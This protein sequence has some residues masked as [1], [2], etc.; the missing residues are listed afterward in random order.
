MHTSTKNTKFYI[1]ESAKTNFM[2]ISKNWATPLTIASFTIMSITG[3]LL[4][5][6]FN[7]GIGKLVHKWGGL[8]LTLAVTLHIIAN[9]FG[10]KRYFSNN[11][12][13]LIFF[14]CTLAFLGVTLFAI[15]PAKQQKIDKIILERFI[16]TPIKII[17]PLTKHST[18]EVINIL[19]RE[20]F[21]NFTIDQSLN[22]ITRGDN[23]QIKRII[24]IILD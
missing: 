2:K 6:H 17:T 10:F 1:I 24:P 19:N 12:P 13:S 9:W 14:L 20:G 16:H 7:F 8:A 5:F 23:D 4:F 15:T 11:I 22:E 18:E 3:I 21:H